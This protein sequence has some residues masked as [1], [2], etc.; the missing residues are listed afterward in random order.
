MTDEEKEVCEYFAHL[1]E[2]E[3][4]ESCLLYSDEPEHKKPQDK[5]WALLKRGSAVAEALAP[6]TYDDG[7]V[8][9]I[10]GLRWKAKRLLDANSKRG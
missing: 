5:F 8:C 3:L 4:G 1:E 6:F 2:H 10:F 9:P 7:R